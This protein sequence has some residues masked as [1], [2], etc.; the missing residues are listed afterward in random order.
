[1]T[2]SNKKSWS[3]QGQPISLGEFR[4]GIKRAEKG[5]FHTIEDA[6]KII[7]EWREK[8]NSL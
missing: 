3:L 2:H 5:P 1:M 6:K 8:K 4:E 7:L